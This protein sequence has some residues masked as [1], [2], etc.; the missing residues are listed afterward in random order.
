MTDPQLKPAIDYLP[1][2]ETAT[3]ARRPSQIRGLDGGH[4]QC[5]RQ[6]TSAGLAS[7]LRCGRGSPPRRNTDPFGAVDQ[8]KKQRNSRVTIRARTADQCPN[9]T[10]DLLPQNLMVALYGR[11]IP[12]L[13]MP[14]SAV[15]TQVIMIDQV[16]VE[17]TN[18]TRPA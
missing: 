8:P 11:L 5:V 18:C 3:R 10:L 12:T 17:M 1:A 15:A 9:R 6:T 2:F 4:N 16:I 7:D 13:C 14:P